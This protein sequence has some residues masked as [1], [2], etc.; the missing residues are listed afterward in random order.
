MNT[1]TL[2]SSLHTL[3]L[4]PM[5]N[6]I[7]LIQDQSSKRAAIVD[8]AWE[9]DK[10]ID[11][12]QQQNFQITDVLLTHSHYDHTNGLT[13][14][15]K[16]YDAH[17]HL[18]EVEAQ[19]W[20]EKLTKPILHHDGDTIQIGKT[21]IEILHTPGHTPGSACYYFDGHLITGDTLFIFG[22]GRCDLIGGDP[23]KMYYSLKKLGAEL[24]AQTIIHPG[25]HYANKPS[26]TL[27]EQL[28]RNPFMQ[29][30][31][32]ADFIHYRMQ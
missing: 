14:I 18:L 8:P 32:V 23:K 11:F 28:K 26:S 1:S 4:G 29:F 27:E 13:Q 7:Y 6:F 30:D 20:G 5:D 21:K 9:I 3:K 22:C 16:A 24:P 2:S 12:A 15:L 19:F 25:H 10:V 17:L 31:N